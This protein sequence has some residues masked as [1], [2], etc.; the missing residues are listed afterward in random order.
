LRIEVGS[1]GTP[2]ECK[3]GDP[4]LPVPEDCH[5]TWNANQW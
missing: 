2:G 4:L 3:P 5:H 1:T